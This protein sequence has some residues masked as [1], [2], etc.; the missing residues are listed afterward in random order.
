MNFK[1]MIEQ[2]MYTVITGILPVV[3]VFIVTYL[4]TKVKENTEKI[5]ND[6]LQK[7]LDAATEAISIAV[8]TISQTYVDSMKKAGTFDEAAQK[9]AKRMAIEKA[10]ELI[11]EDTRKAIE[12]LYSD[13]DK[14]LDAM[15]ESIVRE[16]KIEVKNEEDAA[17]LEQ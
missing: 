17:K 14:Y 1:E 3:T 12:M 8:I 13:F 2:V 15:I 10:K 4:K 7:Y 9:E 11:T 16:S 5:K 6:E